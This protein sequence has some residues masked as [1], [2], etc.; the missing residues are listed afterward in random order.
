MPMTFRFPLL[1]GLAASMLLPLAA[2]AESF[3]P[4]RSPGQSAPPPANSGYSQGTVNAPADASGRSVHAWVNLQESG[5]ES[6]RDSTPM[7]GPIASKV[8]K[9]YVDS[10][11]HPI[12]EH[13]EHQSMGLNSGG[14]S[15]G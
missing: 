10:F 11:S 8:Y 14:G 3:G 13:F 4:H 6:A 1:L 15:G 9:R 12:P 7:P 2:T 5:T